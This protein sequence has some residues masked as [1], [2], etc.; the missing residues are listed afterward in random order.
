MRDKATLHTEEHNEKADEQGAGRTC[1]PNAHSRAA[2][3]NGTVFQWAHGDRS[4]EIIWRTSTTREMK[5]ISSITSSGNSSPKWRRTRGPQVSSYLYGTWYPFVNY[6]DS[7]LGE[8]TRYTKYA[9]D[10]F[11]KFPAT[12]PT[13]F[14]LMYLQSHHLDLDYYDTLFQPGAYLRTHAEHLAKWHGIEE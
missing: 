14:I 9:F 12:V 13:I 5:T 4:V 8:A 1:T 6:L 3:S 2:R 7:F 10:A 11:G